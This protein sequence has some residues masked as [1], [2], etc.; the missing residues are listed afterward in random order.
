M[1]IRQASVKLNH[2]AIWIID[3]INSHTGKNYDIDVVVKAML[4][5]NDEMKRLVILVNLGWDIQVSE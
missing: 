2:S 4:L 5:S 3:E 1:S